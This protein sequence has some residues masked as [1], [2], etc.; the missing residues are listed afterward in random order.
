MASSPPPKPCS[1]TYPVRCRVDCPPEKTYCDQHQCL[2]PT[3]D[4]GR[5][6]VTG[7]LILSLVIPPGF[8]ALHQCN[9]RNCQNPKKLK[10]TAMA[11]SAAHIDAMMAQSSPGLPQWQ[12]GQA[13]QQ[14]LANS[15]TF[16]PAG[17]EGNTVYSLMFLQRVAAHCVLHQCKA[18][19]DCTQPVRGE[20]FCRIH[21]YMKV[22]A[23]DT[24]RDRDSKRH[25][26]HH[27]KSRRHC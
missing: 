1:Y 26:R 19:D 27:R 5:E 23:G 24:D 15:T 8:C 14:N 10:D 3:C 2:W 16:P 4:N 21:E 11:P 17:T 13:M 12:Y 25:R 20:D 22:E 18:N 7:G 6:Y 9:V